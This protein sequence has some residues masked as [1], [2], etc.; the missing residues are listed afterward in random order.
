[1]EGKNEMKGKNFNPFDSREKGN[2]G[3]GFEGSESFYSVERGKVL[4]RK[5]NFF[6]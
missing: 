4:S 5:E 3:E 1:M 6:L 2:R